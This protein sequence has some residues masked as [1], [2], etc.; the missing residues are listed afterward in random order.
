MREGVAA[1]VHTLNPRRGRQVY[2]GEE[3]TVALRAQDDNLADDVNIT[4]V[5]LPFNAVLSDVVRALPS[6]L[7][8]GPCLAS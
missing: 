5:N 7:G 4:G 1:P 2:M 3:M 6:A 8:S